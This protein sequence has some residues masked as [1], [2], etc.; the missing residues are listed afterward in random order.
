[1]IV[2]KEQQM[3]TKLQTAL[4]IAKDQKDISAAA[5]YLGQ[6]VE[7]IT[8]CGKVLLYVNNGETYE[9]TVCYSTDKDYFIDSWGDWHESVEAQYCAAENVIRYG[10]CGE[11]TDMTEGIR[12]NEIVCSHCNNLIGG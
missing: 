10:F 9:N 12:W 1:M 11:F 8:I 4:Q 6:E 2:G 7:N 3:E 5:E